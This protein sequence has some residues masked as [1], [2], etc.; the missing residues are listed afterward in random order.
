MGM[1]PIAPSQKPG[2]WASSARLRYPLLPIKQ[3][4]CLAQTSFFPISGDPQRKLPT[5]LR[6]GI[7]VSGCNNAADRPR[8][9]FRVTCRRKAL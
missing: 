8:Y 4:R 1:P 7:A 6:R 3:K 9:K 5:I 2:K